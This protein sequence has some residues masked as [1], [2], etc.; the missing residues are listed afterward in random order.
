MIYDTDGAEEVN[1]YK[2]YARHNAVNRRYRRAK[3]IFVTL[4]I[5]MSENITGVEKKITFSRKTVCRHCRGTGAHGGAM[6]PC[7][8]CRGRGYA[9]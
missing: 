2:N 4:W 1:Q 7:S 9:L 5:K 6:K 3:S 8:T